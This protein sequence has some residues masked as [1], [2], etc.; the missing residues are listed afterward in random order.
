MKRPEVTKYKDITDDW[1]RVEAPA[2]INLMLSVHGRREDGFHELTSMVAALDFGDELELRINACESD[3][4]ESDG[5][6]VPLDESNLVLRA[7]RL[8][9]ERSGRGECFDFRLRKRIP[10]GAGL[11]GGSSDAVA[12]LKGMDALLGTRMSREELWA[13]A[14][15]LGSDCPFFVEATPAVM[16]GRGEILEAV[17]PQVAA[18]LAGQRVVLF[19]PS[20]AI[21]TGWAYGRLV[22]R[23]QY[24]EEKTV[25]EARIAAFSAGGNWQEFMQ[26]AFEEVVGEKFLALP[27]LLEK[28]RAK[29]S[30]CMM[31]G[32]GS[33]CFALVANDDEAAAL[34]ATCRK[35]WG[36]G[37][38]WVETS[39]VE[40]IM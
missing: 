35:A 1:L 32:S 6:T 39:I 26:N 7:A 15:T 4:L 10:V 22:A 38:F 30:F 29:G 20:F 16:S 40:G 28:L 2:K 12:A 33:A 14:A 23:P 25:A 9:R 37:I 8:F 17:D 18:R 11:G 13:L 34:S 27:C 24:Y 3:S 21:D 19:R 36:E 31:S 5:V